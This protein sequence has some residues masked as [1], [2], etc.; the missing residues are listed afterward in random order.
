MSSHIEQ[1]FGQDRKERILRERGLLPPIEEEVAQVAELGPALRV[2]AVKMTTAV[3]EQMDKAEA[4]EGY[5][6]GGAIGALFSI[7][8][9]I[10]DTLPVQPGFE[11]VYQDE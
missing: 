2:S 8:V 7:P 1:A 3:F 5:V 4:P 9:K 10:D 11:V 6:H